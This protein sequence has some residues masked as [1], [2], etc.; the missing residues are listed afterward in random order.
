MDI[1]KPRPW[2]GWREFANEVAVIVPG[3]PIAL[4]A[5]PAVEEW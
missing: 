1:H 2:C 3:V 4:G 5:E